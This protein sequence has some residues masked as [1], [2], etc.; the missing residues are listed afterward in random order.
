MTECDSVREILPAYLEGVALPAEVERVTAH[1]AVCQECGQEVRDLIKSQKLIRNL[2]E[3]DPPLWLKTRI[4]ARIEE[5]VEEE[6]ESG[7]GLSR[8]KEFLFS[9]LKVKIPLQAFSVLLVA[10]AVF[11]VYRVIQPEL[12]I[13]RQAPQTVA[14][15][16]HEK[17]GPFL[18][19]NRPDKADGYAIRGDEGQ[20][21]QKTAVEDGHK[22]APGI[23]ELLGGASRQPSSAPELKITEGMKD[24]MRR[25]ILDPDPSKAKAAKAYPPS[26]PSAA[27][28]AE[29][30]T[31]AEQKSE[32]AK[33]TGFPST[34]PEIL[35]VT[36]HVADLGAG[37]KEVEAVFRDLNAPASR[38]SKEGSSVISAEVSRQKAKEIVRRL[39]AAG[40]V[41][42]ISQLSEASPDK[43][44]SI[45][46]QLLQ[47]Q[48]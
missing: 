30:R 38:E 13:P 19:S 27:A 42:H 48:P 31:R 10:V 1:L 46:I 8:L 41:Q 39:A 9:P 47:K 45:R 18:R 23:E 22:T 3:Q 37:S 16:P 29:D 28:P 34:K 44:V 4:M 5:G 43:P 36:I 24:E 25:A 20:S 7:W 2:P 11:Y 14:P 35:A 15:A 12:T 40:Q 26:A 21:P 17:G 32:G 33:G 6:E